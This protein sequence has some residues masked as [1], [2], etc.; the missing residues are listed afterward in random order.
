MMKI[1]PKNSSQI[2]II[3]LGISLLAVGIILLPLYPGIFFHDDSLFYLKIANNIS[4]GNGS[5]FDG[6][7]STNG[8]HY[9]YAIILSF[10]SKVFPLVG[11]KGTITVFIFDTL[12]LI[13]SLFIIDSLLKR[14]N[15]RTTLRLFAIISTFAFLGYNDIAMETKMLLPLSWVF[16][17][18]LVRLD[19]SQTLHQ[20]LI[21]L[22]GAIIFFTRIDYL[23]FI[24]ITTG[25]FSFA[26]FYTKPNISFPKMLSLWSTLV[27]L[28]ILALL[29]Y[30][31]F[32]EYVFGYP[33][34]VS[35]WI[36]KSSWAGSYYMFYDMKHYLSS[37]IRVSL[38][39]VSAI[40]SIGY[41]FSRIH[42]GHLKTI[43]SDK[44]FLTLVSINIFI[45]VYM[46]ITSTFSTTAF[47]S[48][49][50]A[51]PLSFTFFI[52]AFLVEKFKNNKV[53]PIILVLGA[54]TILGVNL[55]SKIVG[56]NRY[57]DV[58]M[59]VWMKN[60]LDKNTR[61]FQVDNCGFTGYFSELSV[62]NGD[63]LVNGWEYI[64]AVKSNKLINYIEKYHIKYILWDEYKAGE[65]IIIPLPS[66]H[67]KN[68]M[69]G[70][71]FS[72]EPKK[73]KTIGRF[74]LLKADAKDLEVVN[75]E[76]SNSPVLTRPHRP[77]E[78]AYSN[79]NTNK[80]LK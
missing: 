12:C 31:L 48:W 42:K 39:F 1:E 43:Y 72:K 5:T 10:I 20:I 52:I 11:I 29:F 18:L 69:Q 68:R 66:F 41:I 57:D 36:K 40:T 54:I 67:I 71:G 63:G 24:F 21:S 46:F 8:Y 3:C 80:S 2:V 53:L 56:Y 75:I 27:S 59:G 35:S 62:I 55:T 78:D 49:Y 37:Y 16:L 47:S 22:V 58:S 32:N 13:M 6:I 61:I 74:I 77:D 50:M 25:V 9:L 76:N 73:I 4:L 70:L 79:P 38:I 45:L 7:N 44:G 64:N 19:L 34:S 23:L 51:I 28:S 65:K 14:F 26:Y 17:Y 30:L 33:T 15:V 60:N